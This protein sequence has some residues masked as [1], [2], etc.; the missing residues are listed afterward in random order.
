MMG[1][2]VEVTLVGPGDSSKKMAEA[3]FDELKRVESLTSFHTESAL[4]RLNNAAGTGPVRADTG[5]LAIMAEALRIAGQTNG[6]FD[7][8]VGPLTRIWNFS[9]PGEPKLPA[10]AEIASALGKTGWKK[11]KVDAE[12]GS[13][14]LPEPGMS[15]DLGGIAKGY[16]LDR[17]REV[18]QRSG[19]CAALVNAG[20]DIL[21]VGEKEP[22][23]PWRIGVQ[24]PRNNRGMVAVASLKD[25]IIV[26]SG[27]YQRFFIKNGRRY[28]HILDPQTGYPTEGLRSV[29]IVASEG[30]TADAIAT[31]IF[32]LGLEEGLRYIES[33]PGVAGLLIDSGGRLHFSSTARSLLEPL[34]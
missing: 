33:I 7:P 18:L 26:T 17:V 3:V 10:Q 9:G 14:T 22:G 28:H 12:T 24:D 15:L 31:A 4:S 25:K 20:G 30:I 2:I 32:P 19:A 5:L 1:T 23:K 13:I 11:V 16:A 29:T 21:V 8:T 34:K 6:A 27:D